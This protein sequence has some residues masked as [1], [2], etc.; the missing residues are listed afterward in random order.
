[1]A[2][3]L[4]III[5]STRPGRIAPIIGNWIASVAKQDS[6]FDVDL[7]DLKEIDLPLLDEAGHPRAQNYEHEHTKRWSSIVDEA[8]A[9]VFLTPEY[10]YFPAAALIN[11]LQCLS[12]EW[13]RKPAAVVSW[14]GVS[15]GLRATQELRLLLA[16][17]NMMPLPQTVPLP[18]VFNF[19]GDDGVLHPEQ[20]VTEG[21]T[22][23]FE[24]LKNWAE[25][26]KTLRANA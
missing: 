11:A 4:K 2:L 24:E 22:G 7:V 26:L 9:Y 10:D 12:L 1:M 20:P 15:G 8:D 16:N 3:K 23:M 17:L 21:A 25:A 19:I 13:G 6:D 18:F 14:G 5:G